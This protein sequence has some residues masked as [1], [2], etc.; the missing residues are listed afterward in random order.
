MLES[1]D[2]LERKAAVCLLR[3]WGKLTEEQR[4]LAQADEHVAVR[5]AAEAA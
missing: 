3:R 2:W 4:Q 1:A 5:A